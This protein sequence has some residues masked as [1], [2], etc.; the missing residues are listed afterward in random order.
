MNANNDNN[1]RRNIV[2]KASFIGDADIGKSWLVYV[3]FGLEDTEYIYS[4]I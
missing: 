4:N 1:I 3:Y 2:I